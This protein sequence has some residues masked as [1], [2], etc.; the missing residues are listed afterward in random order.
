ML[1]ILQAST[2]VMPCLVEGSECSHWI[3]LQRKG[4]PE[5]LLYWGYIG[6]ILGL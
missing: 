4:G 1:E 5:G 3:E 2:F 6:D